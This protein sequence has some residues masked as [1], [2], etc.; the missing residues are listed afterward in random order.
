[1]SDDVAPNFFAAAWHLDQVPARVNKESALA[2]HR[3]WLRFKLTGVAPLGDLE[4]LVTRPDAL[5]EWAYLVEMAPSL[6]QDPRGSVIRLKIARRAGE[7]GVVFAAQ[8]NDMKYLVGDLA[9][10]GLWNESLPLLRRMMEFRHV[11]E[12]QTVAGRSFVTVDQAYSLAL[13]ESGRQTEFQPFIAERSRQVLSWGVGLSWED[14]LRQVI[15]LSRPRYSS[16]VSMPN[17]RTWPNA[18]GL[19]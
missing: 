15:Y 7:S 12:E 19:Q 8:S 6:P 5:R 13:Q 9:A 3:A 10:N 17:R 18:S 4:Q 11:L 2:V 1:M 14:E 16:P